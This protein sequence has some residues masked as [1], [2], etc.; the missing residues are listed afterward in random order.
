MASKLETF[1]TSKKIDRRRVVRASHELE[2]LRPEDRAI[3]L[4]QRKAKKEEAQKQPGAPKPRSGRPLSLATIG[5]LIAGKPVSGPTK[6]RLLRAI[7]HILAGRKQE[8]V[9][10]KDLFDAP[11]KP[12]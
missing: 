3:K 8:A 2:K 12:G 4:A 9:A 6:S 10:L 11:K 7:N 1:L 5:K